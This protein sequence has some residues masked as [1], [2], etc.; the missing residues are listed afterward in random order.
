MVHHQ[1]SDHHDH[2]E[3]D[4][5]HPGARHLHAVPH[6]LDPLPAQ[7]PKHDEEG[8]E[9]VVH[10]PARQL[11]VGRDLAH[12]LLVAL[13]KELHAH[14]REDEDDDGQDQRQVAQSPHRITD[15]LD[16]HVEGG[17]RLGQLEDTQLHTAVT[18][19]HTLW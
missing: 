16:Q 18:Q 9:E 15:D 8:V 1:V 17:P 12:A 14:H 5:T 11:T 4:E 13:P 3:D 19:P 10:V 2:H 7:D 6:G